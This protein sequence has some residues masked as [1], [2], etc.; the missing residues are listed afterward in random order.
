MILKQFCGSGGYQPGEPITLIGYSGGAQVALGAVT[1]LK[2]ALDAPIE[3]ISISGVV[4][5]N[6]GRWRSLTG[7]II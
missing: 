4:S 7:Y 1:Y 2:Y 3:V 5:G 6:N